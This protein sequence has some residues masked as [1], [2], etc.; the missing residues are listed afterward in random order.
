MEECNNVIHQDI[1]E[2]VQEKMKKEEELIDISELFKAFGDN[3]RMKIINALIHHELCVC[4]LAY[5]T[6]SS[7]SAVSHQLRILK[8]MKLVTARKVGK[9]VYYQLRDDHVA[10]IFEMGCEH[11][12]EL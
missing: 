1:V 10:K 12:E 9:V 4:D 5:L 2:N 6:K 8:N 3:T 7:L 11:I